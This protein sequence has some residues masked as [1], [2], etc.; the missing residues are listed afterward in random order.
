M[1]GEGEGGLDTEEA[2]PE[3]R[4]V[5]GSSG[6]GSSSLTA[7]LSPAGGALYDHTTATV[8]VIVVD[9]NVPGE[10]C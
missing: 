10:A 7:R 8:S 1:P 5:K 6:N 2:L 3:R 4:V 9:M